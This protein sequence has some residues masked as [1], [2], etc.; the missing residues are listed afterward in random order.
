MWWKYIKP[1]EF[2][3][4]TY[5]TDDIATDFEQKSNETT[6]PMQLKTN[7]EIF[8]TRP[9]ISIRNVE[10]FE[11]DDVDTRRTTPLQVVLD[12]IDE[13]ALDEFNSNIDNH[14]GK[15]TGVT[16]NELVERINIEDTVDDTEA[17]TEQNIT[18]DEE[19]KNK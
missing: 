18:E 19:R 14:E 7:G 10:T 5:D 2:K 6:P 17:V 1:Y 12:N 15:K 16:F 13:T 3:K 4:L 9:S 11:S 8:E